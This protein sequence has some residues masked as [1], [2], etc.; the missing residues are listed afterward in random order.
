MAGK[1]KRYVSPVTCSERLERRKGAVCR[2]GQ[3]RMSVAEE[4]EKLELKERRRQRLPTSLSASFLP[5]PPSD[6]PSPPP[7][8][9]GPLPFSHHLYHLRPALHTQYSVAFLLCDSR[10]GC[11]LC[12]D[13][14]LH[15]NRPP[16]LDSL[17]E[18]PWPPS[19]ITRL[20]THTLMQ[21]MI[22]L[23]N[24]SFPVPL[25]RCASTSGP[26]SC[27][28]RSEQSLRFMP[29]PPRPCYQD[30]STATLRTALN[31]VVALCI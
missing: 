3:G 25:Q 11:L 7:P 17:R 30:T 8:F 29:P 16:L 23:P 1:R 24:H 13:H 10:C 6:S 14:R 28:R 18:L 4:G 31:S 27:L 15:R 26:P 19:A 21:Y 12:S 9:P 22:N 5:P 2:D 20:D